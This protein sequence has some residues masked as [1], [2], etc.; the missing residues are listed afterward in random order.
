M[1]IIQWIN[2]NKEWFFSGVG[3][4]LITS[5]G[6]IIKKIFFKK[7]NSDA[8]E[9]VI[10]QNSVGKHNVQIGIQNNYKKEKK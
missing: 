6:A 8:Q 10:K 9:T 2:D 7:N 3:V 5:F 1:K 4:V